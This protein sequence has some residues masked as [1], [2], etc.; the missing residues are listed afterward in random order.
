[1]HLHEYQAKMILRKYGISVP[2]F[3]AVS[4][5]AEA[6]TA[7]NHMG[8]DQAVVKV[9]VH[10]GGRGKAGGV[11]I[12]KNRQDIFVAVDKL[13]GLKII[14]SQTG[15]E[16]I[17]AE[18]IL[19]SPL[20]DYQKEYYLAAVIDRESAQA[21]LIAS[22]EGGMEIEEIAEKTP[23][24]IKMIPIPSNGV[25]RNYQLI[26]VAKFMGWSGSSAEQG[27]K[28]IAALCKAFVETD[29]LLLEINP[30]VKTTEGDIVALD[31]KLTVD[32]NALYRQ[33][34]I[35]KCYDPTQ[36]TPY[37]ALAKQHDLAYVALDGEIGCMVNG[38][39]LAMAT[40]DIINHYGGSPANFL[41]VGGGASQE[42]VAEGF[43]IILSDHKV[44]AILVNIFGGIMNCVTLAAG[45]VAAT[46]DLKMKVPLII[47]MEGT[48]VEMGKK[49]LEDSGLDVIIAND[50]SEAAQKAV[51]AAKRE[52]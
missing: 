8:L 51:A 32:D 29:A 46:T 26:E 23:D 17:V 36:V 50:L 2:D 15:P 33:P 52:G 31:A 42:K 9:Q 10:A 44:K 40:M 4:S 48:N 37:E 6:K 5:L 18:Q 38:A 25:L 43:K 11:K 27:K 22:P 7:V 14:N 49:I 45:I 3:V 13:I 24:R 28:T 47:R 34:E 41:D 39:G 12:A 1:M 19:I 16:G 20:V 21:M 30:L 35:A